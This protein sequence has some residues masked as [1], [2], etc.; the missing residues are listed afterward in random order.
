MAPNRTRGGLRQG[1]VRGIAK[2]LGA[3]IAT[4]E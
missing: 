1:T 2:P 4:A 3:V